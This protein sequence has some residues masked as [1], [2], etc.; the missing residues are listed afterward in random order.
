M[1]RYRRNYLKYRTHPRPDSCPFCDLE[2]NRREIVSESKHAFVIRN[3][4]KYDLW[5]LRRVVD[6]LMIIP[7][8][9]V[10]SLSELSAEERSDIMEFMAEYASQGY[11]VYAR[12]VDSVHRTVPLHQHTHLIKTNGKVARF[13]LYLLKPYLLI[14]F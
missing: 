10:R 5:E 8:R 9:H 1:F 3:D 11:D 2:K 14:K 4:F 12:S 6:H 13:A 7:R